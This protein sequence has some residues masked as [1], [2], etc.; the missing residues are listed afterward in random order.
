ML[1]PW[2]RYPIGVEIA[3]D[4]RVHARVWA[5]RRKKVDVLVGD[6][7]NGDWRVHEL[8]E[9]AG[10]YFS[11]DV[12]GAAQGSK[13]RFRLDGR[14][15]FPDPASR[16][17]P[18]GPHGPSQIVDSTRY[19]W[20]DGGWSGISLSKQVLYELHV[21]TFTAEG[22][23]RAAIERLDA[24]TDIGITAIEVMP[25]AE[26]AGAFGWGYDGV[27]LFAPTR[28]YGAPDDFR[29]LV[30]EAHRRGIGVILD[31]VYNHLGP[32]GSYLH[33]FSDWYFSRRHRTEWGDALNFDDE[34]A[35]PV[36]EFVLANARYWIDEF[37]L[38]GLR[39]D[40]TQQIFDE[41]QTHIVAEV[42]LCARDAA[43][44]RGIIVIA[45]NEPQDTRLVRPRARGGYELDALWND[46][47]HHAAR[48]AATGNDEAYFS[49]YRGSAQEFVSAAKYGYLYQGE[50]Y[51][52][53]HQ[54]RGTPALD[55]PP[56]RFVHFIQNHDQIANSAIG[57]RI[58]QRTSAGRYRAL[59]VLT[60]LLPQTP[61]LFMG[62]EFAASA[63]FIYFADHHPEL[64]RMVKKGREEFLSQF[65][66]L[67][68]DE[69]HAELPDPAS[70][71][72]FMQCKLDWSERDSHREAVDLH[73]DVIALR[74]NDPVFSS[75]QPHALDG[76][77]LSHSTF[78]LRWFG[79]AGDRL[80]VV[81]LGRRLHVDPWAEPLIA[82]PFGH[83][84]AMHWSSEH[85]RY[86]GAGT[87]P[88]DS[89]KDGWWLPA[90][91]AVVLSPQPHAS[92]SR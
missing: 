20:R 73:R 43:G 75:A 21:G 70:P 53:Q 56:S 46:D 6:G 85:P 64:A 65:P 44:E 68:T 24:L 25:V 86:G 10:G 87:P 2:R 54:R 61:M 7:E 91:C 26:F 79:A 13:Y 83:S 36:R 34:H 77:V 71:Q 1:P 66:T 58:H 51:T 84:W 11:G 17:Q 50:W 40:A 33:E 81:N 37:H 8:N 47:Y 39:L 28:L 57:A 80:L 60:L 42:A 5:P 88:I 16:F 32:D 45:E 12:P 29:A 18:A 38:D 89:Q 76:S 72:S 27:D 69:G 48:V 15:A 74:R 49:G 67:Q 14:D 31:V 19:K 23:F 90:E 41:S 62:Q 92:P 22:T 55:I 4:G 9:E 30:E 52:W 35:L 78:V 59:T 82:P 63:P 3:A